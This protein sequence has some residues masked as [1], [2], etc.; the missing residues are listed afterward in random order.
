MSRPQARDAARV[1]Y[2]VGLTGLA[3][4]VW[5]LVGY[6]FSIEADEP[7][8]P[9]WDAFSPLVLAPLLIVLGGTALTGLSAPPRWRVWR[10]VP[11][12]ALLANA[13]TASIL[14]ARP[15]SEWSLPS[16]WPYLWA[17]A[18]L[19]AVLGTWLARPHG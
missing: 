10:W 1:L 18:L 16:A 13:V 4:L 19:A 2:S 7:G 11:P 5:W 9:H 14:A 15:E 12:L 8:D 3:L 6:V 17:A